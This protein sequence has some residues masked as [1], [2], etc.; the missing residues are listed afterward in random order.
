MNYRRNGVRPLAVLAC[1]LAMS[2]A[3]AGQAAGEHGVALHRVVLSRTWTPAVLTRITRRFIPGGTALLKWRH[4]YML[5]KGWWLVVR[6]PTRSRSAMF[7][8]WAHDVIGALYI[9]RRTRSAPKLA[10][11]SKPVRIFAQGSLASLRAEMSEAAPRVGLELRSFWAPQLGG[12]MAPVVTFTVSAKAK[13]NR[14][15]DPGCIYDWVLPWVSNPPRGLGSGPAPFFAVFFTIKDS[16]GRWLERMSNVSEGT[17]TRTSRR[18]QRLIPARYRDQGN[19]GIS[20]CPAG[21]AG[22]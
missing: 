21:P 19:T 4:P 13:F 8:E 1:V 3:G 17:E 16:A 14:W 12:M 18:G 9:D 11:T 22:A 6:D 2:S 5:P 7:H 10:E 15:F 20:A